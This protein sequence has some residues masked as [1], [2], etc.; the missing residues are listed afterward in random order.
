MVDRST[1]VDVIERFI[2]VIMQR[3]LKTQLEKSIMGIMCGS[4][5]HT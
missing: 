4:R 1:E 2:M 5:A 3:V